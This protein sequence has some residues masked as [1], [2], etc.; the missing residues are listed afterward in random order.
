MINELACQRHFIWVSSYFE[1][2]N[3]DMKIRKY[4]EMKDYY[5]NTLFISSN[6]W[7]TNKWLNLDCAIL[8]INCCLILLCSD[9]SLHYSQQILK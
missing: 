2:N 9:H 3:E 8:E 5:K 7:T 6:L 4:L 1:I